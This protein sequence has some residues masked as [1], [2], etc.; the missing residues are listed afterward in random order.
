MAW[1]VQTMLEAMLA[2]GHLVDIR[3]YHTDTKVHFKL[4]LTP[5]VCVCVCARSH[6][7]VCACARSH[8]CAAHAHR[9]LTRGHMCT[10]I[11]VATNRSAVRII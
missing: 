1:P 11:A 8:L 9:K 10:T 2:A 3:E 4:V 7:R 5:E 6:L